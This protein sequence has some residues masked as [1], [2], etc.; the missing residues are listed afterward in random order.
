MNL[1]VATFV[2]PAR[3]PDGCASRRI[4]HASRPSVNSNKRFSPRIFF[5][6]LG[7]GCAA[8]M[9]AG[10][11]AACGEAPGI[12]EHLRIANA[13]PERGR[14]LIHA[15]GCGTCHR[16]GD[17]RGARGTVGPPLDNFAERSVVAGILPNT[18]RV[19]VAWLVDPP[20]IDARTAMPAVGLDE[21]EAR[22]VAAYLYTLGSAR[23]QVYP[24]DPPLDLSRRAA[25]ALGTLRRSV[26]TDQADPTRFRAR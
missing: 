26:A 25:P 8:V 2:L 3:H 12:P 19:L 14:A 18:P 5:C 15:Y 23:A 1:A 4:R 22:H 16:I 17:V 10:A 9:I 7:R 6:A 24:P 21:A 20:A 13:E 11:L